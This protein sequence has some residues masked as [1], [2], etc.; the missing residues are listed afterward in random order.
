MI[1]NEWGYQSFTDHCIA[2]QADMSSYRRRKLKIG[3]LAAD[4]RLYWYRHD[5]F[6]AFCGTATLRL[7]ARRPISY[8]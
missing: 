6:V 2:P 7:R 1:S 5:Q 8:A 3:A 4:R